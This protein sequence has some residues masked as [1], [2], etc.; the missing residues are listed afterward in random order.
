MKPLRRETVAPAVLEA[1]QIHF[2]EAKVSGEVAAGA[3]FAVA[4]LAE[5]NDHD[6]E[7]LIFVTVLEMW[8]PYQGQEQSGRS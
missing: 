7:T 4:L 2:E 3:R 8:K 1:V 6:N 5:T